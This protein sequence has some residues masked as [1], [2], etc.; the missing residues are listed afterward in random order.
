VREIETLV[1]RFPEHE[2]AVRRLYARDPTFR[3]ICGDYDEALRGLRQWQSAD[4][5]ANDRIEQYRE[6]LNDLESEALK[7]VEDSGRYGSGRKV[8]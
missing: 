4:T 2:L 3:T 1:R 5:P 6:L 7:F 8:G